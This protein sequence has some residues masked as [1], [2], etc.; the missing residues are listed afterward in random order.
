MNPLKEATFYTPGICQNPNFFSL[1]R[2]ATQIMN[3]AFKKAARK[4]IL[5]KINISLNHTT[6][7]TII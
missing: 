6:T 2:Q 5:A 4:P 3:Y 7:I 1:T